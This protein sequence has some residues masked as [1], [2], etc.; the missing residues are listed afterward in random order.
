MPPINFYIYLYLLFGEI[1]LVKIQT[2]LCIKFSLIVKITE[3]ILRYYPDFIQSKGV[4]I[5]QLLILTFT[6]FKARKST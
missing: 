5:R 3:V 6:F 4:V 1:F 2:N